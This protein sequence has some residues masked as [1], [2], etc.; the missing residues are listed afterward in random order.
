MHPRFEEV[1]IEALCAELNAKVKIVS[2]PIPTVLT[3]VR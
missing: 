2:I 1:D 3:I